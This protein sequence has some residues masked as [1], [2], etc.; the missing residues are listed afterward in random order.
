MF[1]LA[2]FEI[3]QIKESTDREAK[4]ALR[5]A[6]TVPAALRIAIDIFEG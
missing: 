1:K 2:L 3:D 5:K 6:E 4:A